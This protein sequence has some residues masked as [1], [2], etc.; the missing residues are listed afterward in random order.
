MLDMPLRLNPELHNRLKAHSKETG[1]S[2]NSIVSRAVEEFL[3]QRKSPVFVVEDENGNTLAIIR[4]VSSGDEFS[5]SKGM[6]EGRGEKGTE[7]LRNSSSPS[8]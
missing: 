5:N 2:M 1:E 6:V 7:E 8:E 4:S 3:R